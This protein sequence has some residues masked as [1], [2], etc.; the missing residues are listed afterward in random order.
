MSKLTQ[1]F[2]K[3]AGV[4]S[5]IAPLLMLAADLL[6][7]G[8]L[9][10]E[11]T[12]VLWLAFVFFVPAILGLTY[13]AAS[14]GSRLALVGGASAYFGTMAGASMQVLF[15]VWAVLEEQNSPQ[16]VELLQ[17]TL[18]LI[19]TTQMIG[20][21]FPIGLLIL[22]VCLYRNR[23]VSPIIVLSLAA[24]AILFPVGRIGGF[25]WAFIGSDLLLIAAFG[26]IGRRLLSADIGSLET[27]NTP[28]LS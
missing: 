24:G 28:A 23:V 18:K 8:G 13:L 4:C 9:K 11:F 20:I 5:I 10:F 6:Q 3:T 27:E 26:L 14:Y 7:I 19:A 25:W 2:I 16:T 21:F 12:L 15:R 17:K 22:A 1:T